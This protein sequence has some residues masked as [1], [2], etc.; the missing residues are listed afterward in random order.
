MRRRF[1]AAALCAAMLVVSGVATTPSP[2]S[3]A[4]ANDPVIIVAGTSAAQPIADVVY[5]GLA[6]RLR[7][8]G[9]TPYI[10]G[11][12]G[13]GLGDIAAT[14]QAL[15]QFADQVRSQTG[16]LK[17]DLVGHSQ[18]G[19][20]GRYYIK[21]LGGAGEV[22][23]MIS[24]GAPHYGTALANLATFLGLGNC[25]GVTACE[26]M[27][28]G[29][30]FLNNLNAGDDTIGDVRYTNI[31]TVFD[32]VVVPYWNGHLRNDGNNANVTVQVPCFARLVGHLTLATDG[33]V[34]DGVRD[35][36]RHEPIRLNCFAL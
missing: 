19:L 9:Y 28:A 6:A 35:A 21:N 16:A 33:T 10:F 4:P 8:D 34:Y 14:A 25:L 13:F 27:A 7:A 18:G 17:V 32:E 5:S 23:S 11:L 3:A 26:Q 20:V 30:A 29:S 12:P 24:L 31:V 22:D 1:A 2:A 36:L 15:N